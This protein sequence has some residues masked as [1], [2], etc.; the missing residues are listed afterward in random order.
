MGKI[1][2]E[3]LKKISFRVDLSK[4]DDFTGGEFFWHKTHEGSDFWIDANHTRTDGKI[5]AEAQA[6]I[7]EMIRVWNGGEPQP[8]PAIEYCI[9]NGPGTL[10]D[11]GFDV[12]MLR[13]DGFNALGTVYI[14]PTTTACM[15]GK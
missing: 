11:Y 15:T 6:I 5:P 1:T 8:D 14:A 10:I 4:I 13:F 2:R 3:Y 9:T 7:N 12:G